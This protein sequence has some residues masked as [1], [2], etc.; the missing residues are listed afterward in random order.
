MSRLQ[1]KQIKLMCNKDKF[2]LFYNQYNCLCSTLYKLNIKYHMVNKCSHQHSI[3]QCRLK[4][5]LIGLMCDIN[6]FLLQGNWYN[7]LNL[8][9]Y[10]SNIM[11]YMLDMCNRQYNILMSSFN[12]MLKV[13]MCNKVIFLLYD[14]QYNYLYLT[15]HK[16][17]IKYYMLNKCSHQHSILES[18]LK[19]KLIGLMCNI[20]NFLLQ[21]N[22]YNYLCQIL[23]N[24]Y[25]MN[26]KP[27]NYR[28]LHNILKSSL[29]YK[30]IILKY[31]MGKNQL[32]HILNKQYL[33][34]NK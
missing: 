12:Y 32:N 3:Q 31:N 34:Q 28:H 24:S 5:K 8:T 15:L 33:I 26:Y 23:Y 17:N 22:Q 27:N 18:R 21:G 6:N 1:Y 20:N 7:C 16:L 14:N 2:L 19:Y 10:K 11:N 9:L 4:Y 13:Q 29:K 30:L 25:I